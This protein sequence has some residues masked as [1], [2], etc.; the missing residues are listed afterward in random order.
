[1]YGSATLHVMLKMA[2][3]REK[4]LVTCIVFV[5]LGRDLNNSAYTYKIELN[6][7]TTEYKKY[8]F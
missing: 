2:G 1:M 8:L 5:D 3:N 6:L 7:I 4:W